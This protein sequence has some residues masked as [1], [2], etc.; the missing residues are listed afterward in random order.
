MK[1]LLLLGSLPSLIPVIEA[2]RRL[3]AYV[4]TCDYLPHGIA[5]KYSDEWHNASI[6]DKEAILSLARKLRIDGIMSFAVDPGVETAAYVAE[7]MGL[8]FA[9][10]YEAV[11]ILQNK[12][13]FRAFLAKHAFNVPQSRGYSEYTDVAASIS[14]FTF[15]VIVKPTDSAGSKGVTKIE[16]PQQLKEAF[17]YAKA[18]S[19][20]SRVIVEEYIRQHGCSSDTDCFLVN[21]NL[22]YSAFNAQHFDQQAANPH[23]PAA[24]SWPSTFTPSQQNVLASEIQRLAHLLNLKTSIFNIETRVDRESR[25][26]IMEM[27]PRG[28]GPRLAEMEKLVVGTDLIEAAVRAALNLPLQQFERKDTTGHWAEI[29]LHLKGDKPGTFAG[30]EISEH[31]RH[32]LHD[33]QLHVSPGQKVNPLRGA[34]DAIGTLIIN[35]PDLQTQKWALANQNKWIT[36]NINPIQCHEKNS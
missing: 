24:Y 18:H 1:K 36:L 10:S 23:V 28:G 29:V 27:S 15:P 16:N 6:V 17:D 8:P 30:L 20:K 25:P 32:Y 19:L 5:H 34:G 21:G 9:G 31:M 22:A 14:R 4:I 35:F 13:L 12:D 7:K 3:D 33:I 26:Y 11:R 2:A